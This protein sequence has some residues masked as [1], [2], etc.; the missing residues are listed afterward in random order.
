MCFALAA[1]GAPI[2]IPLAVEP[3]LAAEPVTPPPAPR[4]QVPGVLVEPPNT[5]PSP[6]PSDNGPAG[7]NGAPPGER[8]QPGCP[9]NDRKLELLV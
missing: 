5:T 8:A 1:A 2:F 7:R 9:A 4:R 3:A 6:N